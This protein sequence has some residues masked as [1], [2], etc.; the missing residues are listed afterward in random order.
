MQEVI[1]KNEESSTSTK[2]TVL[3]SVSPDADGLSSAALYKLMKNIEFEIECPSFGN[4][5]PRAAYVFDQKPADPNLKVVV[6]DHHPPYPEKH[7]WELHTQGDKKPA[8]LVVAEHL[9]IKEGCP[10]AWRIPIGL[11][12][13]GSSAMTPTWIW[14]QFRELTEITGYP[15]ETYGQLRISPTLAYEQAK[16]L[17]NFGCRLGAYRET[18]SIYC[19]ATDVSDILSSR[20]LLDCREKVNKEMKRVIERSLFVLDFPRITYSEYS[21]PYKL[22]IA[23]K[24]H[25]LMHKTS[26]A[27]NLED[28]TG[29]IRGSLATLVIEELQKAG[30][31]AGGHLYTAFGGLLFK[32]EEIETIKAVLRRI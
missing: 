2:P 32:P 14:R 18:F 17:I 8:T 7:N 11:D 28:G 25:E 16:S 5:N 3:A 24:G 21:S 22:W 29:S 23:H 20:Y 19:D 1:R 30:I 10:H 31:N 12:G 9:G 26:V 4:I 15:K 13:D 6:F 27:L